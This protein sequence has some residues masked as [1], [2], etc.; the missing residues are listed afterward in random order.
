M[1]L[2][3]EPLGYLLRSE[4][5]LAILEAI[6]DG[7]PRPPVEVRR[8]LDLHPQTFKEAVD[9]LNDFALLSLMVPPGSRARRTAR[10]IAVPLV[11]RITAEGQELLELAE[12]VRKF[13]REEAHRRELH[14]PAATSIRWLPA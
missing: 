1:E 4:P 14:R 3:K 6:Q 9:H 12:G 7:R 5:A 11:I 10:G 8:G 2:E 13:I